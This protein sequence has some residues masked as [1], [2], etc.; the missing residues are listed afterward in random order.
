MSHVT[1]FH[2]NP[3]CLGSQQR[4]VFA[5]TELYIHT[6]CVNAYQ[7]RHISV[8]PHS[9]SHLPN[10]HTPPLPPPPPPSCLSRA[11]IYLEYFR[12]PCV[13]VCVCVCA[14]ARAFVCVTVC[15]RVGVDLLFTHAHTPPPAPPPDLPSCSLSS[16]H[17]R[18][19]LR[20][21]RY[22]HY[23]GIKC[24]LSLSVSLC[25]SVCSLSLSLSFSLPLSALGTY[26][27]IQLPMD[28]SAEM[29]AD[30]ASEVDVAA[31]KNQRGGA[32]VNDDGH[33]DNS[34]IMRHYINN[35]YSLIIIH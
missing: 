4:F 14:R 5:A 19:A 26:A 1:T 31:R 3:C 17:H 11:S 13:C 15:A 2:R 35:A 10:S 23:F 16:V 20:T 33:D 29:K 12:T 24:S 21:P 30:A 34:L 28:S 32:N 22:G 18:T 27:T 9:L 6:L 25:L 7:I 8:S